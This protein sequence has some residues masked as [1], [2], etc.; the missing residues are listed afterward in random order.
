MGMSE[1]TDMQTKTI[2]NQQP[3]ILGETEK[4]DRGRGRGNNLVWCQRALFTSID[5]DLGTS[6]RTLIGQISGN[7]VDLRTIGFVLIHV[8]Q[9]QRWRVRS[10]QR[11]TDGFTHFRTSRWTCNAR[12]RNV[13]AKNFD[14]ICWWHLS[15]SNACLLK[16]YENNQHLQ[17]HQIHNEIGR[18]KTNTSWSVG[19]KKTLAGHWK[20]H[21]IA[22]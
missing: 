8:L 5:L 20:Q 12:I 10:T 3:E 15:L 6:T 18:W 17:R 7:S 16:R 22:K 13:L 4:R 14:Q 9:I 2:S 11:N 21:Y 19:K 1:T